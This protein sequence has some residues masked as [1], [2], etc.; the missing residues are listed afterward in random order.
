MAKPIL[1]IKVDRLLNDNSACQIIHDKV[2]RIL[3][4]EY[5]VIVLPCI[6]K[7]EPEFQALNPETIEQTDIES[8]R[9]LIKNLMTQ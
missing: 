7:S 8:I 6:G 1:I 5:H 3:Q 9:E 2:E 4:G